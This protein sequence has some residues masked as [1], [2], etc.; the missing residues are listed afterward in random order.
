MSTGADDA[1]GR[2]EPEV[3]VLDDADALAG[4]V[5]GLLLAQ[6]AASLDERPAP[7]PV[8][9]VLTGGRVGGKTLEAVAAAAA[10]AD[11]A[12]LDWGRVHLWFGDERFL[13]SGDDERNDVLAEG[14]LLT[15]PAL[16]GAR[17]HRFPA[18]VEGAATPAEQAGQA[19][20]RYAAELSGAADDL[21]EAGTTGTAGVPAFDV[22]L[23]GVGPDGHVASLF[24]GSSTLGE[25][26]VPVVVET[27]APKP[28][29]LRL[30]LGV[31]AVR[32][33]ARVWLVVAGEDKAQA[34][35]RGLDPAEDAARTPAVL[36]RGRL[37]TTWLVDRAAA[38]RLTGGGSPEA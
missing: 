38:S 10:D 28:P 32:A 26:G 19:A 24:P 20:A 9:V 4:H 16:H 33:A 11:V 31:D 34:V 7:A 18:P 1:T 6:V 37:A 27:D 5:A 23:L 30:S 15:A 14:A 17:W 25:R 13:P 35:A 21:G 12:G 36:A 8:H 29:P 2:P 22:L 3:V